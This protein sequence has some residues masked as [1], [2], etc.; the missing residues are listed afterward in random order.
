MVVRGFW[1]NLEK[2]VVGL[3]PMDGVTDAA[4]R[5]MVCK[6]SSPSL[7]MTEFTN[8]EGLARGATKMMTAFLYDEIERPIVGQ[9]YGVEV[10][11]FYKASVMLCAM[12]FDGVDINMGCPANKVARFGSGAAL[13]KT[14]ELAK[15]IIEACKN[16]CKDWANGI[17]MKEAGVHPD[18]ILEVGKMNEGKN[19][20]RLEH[21]EIPVSIKTRIGYDE[22][23]AKEWV[24][25]LLEL[26]PANITMHGR[27]LKQMYLG[28]ADWDVIAGAAAICRGSGTNFVGNG[29]V[30]SMEDAKEKIDRYGVDGV[31]VG[32]AL[33]GNPWFFG[34]HEPDFVER[35]LTVVEHSKYFEGL[36]HLH[37]HNIRKHLAWYCKGFEGAKEMR[38]KLMKT[39]TAD[40][41]AEIINLF[42]QNV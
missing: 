14:P 37:F 7:V 8:V 18:I 39:D 27:T 6:K 22:V 23:V 9:I 32:K 36:E 19:P 1:E 12:G 33:F 30:K 16:G 5:Y 11:S 3:A 21:K 20:E 42:L 28:E 2:P 10:E 24:K 25:H 38:M 41:V 15:K 35:L 40:E 34:E 17:T 31:L 13:I 29:D 26:E 4:F